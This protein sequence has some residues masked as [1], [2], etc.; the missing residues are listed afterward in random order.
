ML[1]QR[2]LESGVVGHFASICN[3]H[4]STSKY[5]AA[6]H[7]RLRLQADIIDEDIRKAL[8]TQLMHTLHSEGIAL[9]HRLLGAVKAVQSQ[10][11]VWQQ[12]LHLDWGVGSGYGLSGDDVPLTVLWAVLDD[13][14]L[15][16]VPR[17]TTESSCNA[18]VVQHVVGRDY[19]MVFRSDVL[20]GG[21][22]CLTP[23]WRLFAR[24][25][26]KRVHGQVASGV[27]MVTHSFP[28][29]A[30]PPSIVIPSCAKWPSE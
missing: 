27:H 10:S 6:K 15:N 12:G 11:G 24:L 2:L 7:D 19:A 29:T 4:G 18:A 9:H 23:N 1:R 28:P 21:G 3:G 17:N 16:L 8:M 5:T 13:F 26:S 30:E 25:T 14:S 22:A 20:H